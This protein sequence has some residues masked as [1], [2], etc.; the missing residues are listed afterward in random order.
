[1][2]IFFSK[3]RKRSRNFNETM[4]DMQMASKSRSHK[5]SGLPNLSLWLSDRFEISSTTVIIQTTNITASRLDGIS[6]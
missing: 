1:M 3:N 6:R 5:V 2:L 4:L